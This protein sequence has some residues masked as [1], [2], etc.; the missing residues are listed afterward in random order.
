MIKRSLA[1]AAAVALLCG[2]SIAQNQTALSPEHQ[3]AREIFKQLIEINTT[4]TPAGNVTTA[5]EAM[6]ARFQA[7]GFPAEDIHLDGP[8][9]NKKNLEDRLHGRGIGK[10]K[11]FL[12]QLYDV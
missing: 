3:A 10:P 7:A 9:P 11:L 12:D 2:V 8:L 4:D 5:A 1:Q 6:A